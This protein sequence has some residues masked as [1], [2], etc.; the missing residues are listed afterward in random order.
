MFL[1]IILIKTLS[2]CSPWELFAAQVYLTG[3]SLCFMGTICRLE[4]TVSSF[5]VLINWEWPYSPI[6]KKYIIRDVGISN[7]EFYII[8]VETFNSSAK[9]LEFLLFCNFFLFLYQDICG[10]GIPVAVQFKCNLSPACTIPT[11]PTICTCGSSIKV[12]N[13]SWIKN[14][15][16]V[17]KTINSKAFPTYLKRILM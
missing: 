15:E 6:Q 9:F 12:M 7:H 8:D 16:S 14:T 11:F 13:L 3:S 4:T 17:Y 10:F 2:R 5:V 1:L